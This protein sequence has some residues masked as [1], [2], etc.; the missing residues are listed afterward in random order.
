MSELKDARLQQHLKARN[1]SAA[2]D[3]DIGPE[4]DVLA[5]ISTDADG[6]EAKHNSLLLEVFNTL[7]VELGPKFDLDNIA[8]MLVGYFDLALSRK[9]VMV[10]KPISQKYET[11]KILLALR[12]LSSLLNSFAHFETQSK[13]K[14]YKVLISTELGAGFEKRAREQVSSIRHDSALMEDVTDAEVLVLALEKL[15]TSDAEIGKMA[16]KIQAVRTVSREF[17]AHAAVHA[18]PLGV[19]FFQAFCLFLP[20][21]GPRPPLPQPEL[22]GGLE[23]NGVTSRS[24]G[25]STSG[26]FTAG[27]SWPGA[28]PGCWVN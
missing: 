20:P 7:E 5:M 14:L 3:A 26:G 6:V 9:E 8:S 23:S 25:L 1:W 28:A 24:L 17:A 21:L 13:M 19:S 16:A 27:P 11:L 10:T 4:E 18:L 12:P 2:F 22:F 15:S